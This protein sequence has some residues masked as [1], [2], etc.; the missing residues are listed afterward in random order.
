M[1]QENTEKKKLIILIV[2][3]AFAVLS[4]VRGIFTPSAIRRDLASTPAETAEKTK[5]AAA[6]VTIA[7]SR[8]SAKKS[9]HDAWGRNPF[10]ATK[11]PGE[12]IEELNLGGILW[13]KDK[14]VAIINDNMVG[15]GDAVGAYKVV[16]ITQ[17]SVALNDGTE[18]HTLKLG[19]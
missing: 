11:K 6:R 8:R 12:P 19:F 7:P 3:G 9:K 17:D 18:E 16:D 5:P 4:L 14:P 1:K 13:D 15:I 2:L 10:V